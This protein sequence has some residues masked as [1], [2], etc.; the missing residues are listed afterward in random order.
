M[1]HPAF[2]PHTPLVLGTYN[3]KKLLELC[4]LLAPLN[5]PLLT[6]ADFP[7]AITVEETGDTFAA[8]AALKASEQA[9]HLGA[10]VLGEDSG[11][12]VDALGGRPGV[13][14]AR[15]AGPGASDAAEQQSAARGTGRRSRR[16]VARLTTPAT[17]P[18]PIRRAR[19]WP[20]AKPTAAG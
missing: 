19:S 4:E 11:L 15:Y 16:I 18:S 17:L 9:V 1:T 13:Y 5:S 10:W 2:P 8:N 3:L 20:V 6:L 14:S 12:S 7:Q